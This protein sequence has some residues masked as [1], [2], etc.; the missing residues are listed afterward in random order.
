MVYSHNSWNVISWLG[1]CYQLRTVMQAGVVV[2]TSHF[3]AG[4]LGGILP[5]ADIEGSNMQPPSCLKEPP[6]YIFVSA[7]EHIAWVRGQGLE[8][9]KTAAPSHS[10][11][12]LM[13]LRKGEAL[14]RL[15]TRGTREV[16]FNPD[17]ISTGSNGTPMENV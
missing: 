12:P 7:G 5:L 15:P 6:N 9:G 14:R 1:C 3:C 16:R 2:Q 8:L 13:Q 10:S 17:M 4:R 11:A